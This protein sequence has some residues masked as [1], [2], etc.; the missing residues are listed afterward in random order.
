M[1]VLAYPNRSTVN[2]E[3]GMTVVTSEIVGHD[4]DIP[5]VEPTTRQTRN[6]TTRVVK[7]VVRGQGGQVVR[8]TDG[9]KSRPV[10][11]RTTWR[12]E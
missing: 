12:V 1:T 9:T 5:L 3:P 7:S 10:N 11:G 6:R 4:F 2:L 8:F